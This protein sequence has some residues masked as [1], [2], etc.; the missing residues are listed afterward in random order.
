MER[1]CPVIELRQYTLHPGT[2]ET[3]VR[4]FEEHFVEGQEQHGMR[5]VG[6]FRDLDAP[7]RFVWIRGFTDMDA[8]ARALEAFYSGPVWKQHGP[9]ANATMIDHTNVLLLRPADAR[10]GFRFDPRRRPSHDA[11]ESAGGMLVAT[12]HHLA[13]PA[14][15]EVAAS[16]RESPGAGTLLGSFVTER[17]RNTFPR[18]PVREDANV[19]V[20]FVSYPGPDAIRPSAATSPA[21]ARVEHLRLQPTRRSF[22]RHLPLPPGERAE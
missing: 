6:Q 14:S 12:I 11:V 9:V 7:D 4:V 13:V 22:L 2:R 5:I 20:T 1:C 10:A 17:A 8:R 15:P 18:L 19:L 21:L 16:L 3:L